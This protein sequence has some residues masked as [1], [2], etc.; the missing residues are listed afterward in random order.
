M[1]LDGCGG[2]G[3]SL[4]MR[5]TRRIFT[6]TAVVSLAGRSLGQSAERASSNNN[7][8]VSAKEQAARRANNVGAA[9]QQRG[10]GGGNR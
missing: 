8:L 6:W 2:G 4:R 9:Q 5:Q 10:G 3:G 1:S 7:A